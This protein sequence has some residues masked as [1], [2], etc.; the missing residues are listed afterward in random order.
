[1]K[2]TV[3]VLSAAVA[4]SVM[5]APLALAQD[6]APSAEVKAAIC[7]SVSIDAVSFPADG[8]VAD[9]ES[10]LLSA[11]TALE[12]AVTA[13]KT[14]AG[15]SDA[16]A[17][18]TRLA[19]IN[20]RIAQLEAGG[21]SDDEK[22]EYADRLEQ[23]RLVQTVIDR[24]SDVAR[25]ENELA[26]ARAAQED[27]VDLEAKV[28]EFVGARPYATLK[29]DLCGPQ[30]A[31]T[32]TPVPTTTPAPTTEPFPVDLDCKD[33]T[34]AEAQK[35]LDAD[36]SD[37]HNLDSDEDGLACDENDF[38]ESVAVPS[39]GVATGGGPA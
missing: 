24:Q 1:M 8:R 23:R 27:A 26:R 16:G 38:N 35:V 4:L 13:A 28:R 7:A 9:A 17:A 2:K 30:P 11:K 36:L 10:R 25:A 31:P 15:L 12:N 39:G 3:L 6:D 33:L 21:V 19:E 5:T 22:A 14:G 32:T 34:D 20:G 37:P 18:R 29:A